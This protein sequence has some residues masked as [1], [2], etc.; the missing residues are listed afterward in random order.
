MLNWIFFASSMNQQFTGS[1]V[2]L[3]VHIIMTLRRQVLVLSCYCCM[4]S[5]EA[6]VA[7][8]NLVL[9]LTVQ[10]NYNVLHSSIQ[11]IILVSFFSQISKQNHR[12]GLIREFY[13]LNLKAWSIL[14][15]VPLLAQFSLALVVFDL[16]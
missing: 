10:Q 8:V 2:A 4:I 3:L 1:H 7:N 13:F 15:L 14:L 12:I 11:N 6:H 9:G 16:G 5:R